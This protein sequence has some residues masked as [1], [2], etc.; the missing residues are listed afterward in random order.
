MH[1]NFQEDLLHDLV[2][3]KGGTDWLVAPWSSLF[4]FFK[5]GG[6]VSSFPVSGNLTGLSQLLRYDG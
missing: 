5:N 1:V 4:V 3:D 2:R 6:Y